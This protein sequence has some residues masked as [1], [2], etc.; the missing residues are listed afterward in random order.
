MEHIILSPRDILAARRLH[1]PPQHT[2][3]VA[4]LTT[5]QQQKRRRHTATAAALSCWCYTWKFVF[6]FIRVYLYFVFSGQ[7]VPRAE[8]RWNFTKKNTFVVVGY[9]TFHIL[10]FKQTTSCSFTIRLYIQNYHGC[11][12]I[13]MQDGDYPSAMLKKTIKQRHQ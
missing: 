7:E 13:V 4:L 5:G 9:N 2:P 3:S 12:D 1:S 8:L 11:F 10:L 6:Y